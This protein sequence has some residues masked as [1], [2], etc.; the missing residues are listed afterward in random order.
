M[1]FLIYYLIATNIC[2]GV[3]KY[4]ALR[5]TQ[6]INNKE[7]KV[8][9]KTGSFYTVI[10]DRNYKISFFLLIDI[11]ILNILLINVYTIISN[12]YHKL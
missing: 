4:I 6:H 11:N 9:Y 7:K 5:D 1:Y 10:T 3:T 2:K 8:E 12:M